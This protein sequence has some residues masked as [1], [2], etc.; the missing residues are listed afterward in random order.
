ANPSGPRR[1]P[2][3][4]DSQAV[5]GYT[6][7]IQRH[8]VHE[9]FEQ[10]RH[11]RPELEFKDGLFRQQRKT[12]SLAVEVMTVGQSTHN[13]AVE[14][15]AN[16]PIVSYADVGHAIVADEAARL[17]PPG[18]QTALIPVAGPGRVGRHLVEPAEFV[19]GNQGTALGHAI[20]GPR[21]SFQIN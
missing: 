20:S 5:L 16:W 15:Q 11:G 9:A 18:E 8:F 7:R 14:S 4:F 6:G 13:V 21:F 3:G 1:K 17:E 2:P 10:S 12:A 19:A